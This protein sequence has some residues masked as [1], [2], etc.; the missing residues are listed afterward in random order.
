MT[1]RALIPA[2]VLISLVFFRAAFV[3]LIIISA[4]TAILA[5]AYAISTGDHRALLLSAIGLFGF[6]VFQMS[7]D[8]TW[9]RK[10]QDRIDR[11]KAWLAARLYTE[12]HT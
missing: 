9:D 11:I 12:P 8:A 5:T 7:F 2:V 4:L 3:L 6:V 10:A 1:R